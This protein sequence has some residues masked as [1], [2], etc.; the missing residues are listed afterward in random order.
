MG[1]LVKIDEI[2][3]G[4]VLEKDVTNPQGAVLLKKG[5]TIS[6]RHISI[7]KTWAVRSIYIVEEGGAEQELNGRAPEEVAQ[8]R[9]AEAQKTL[10]EK[11]ADVISSE[12]MQMIKDLTLK[13]RSE[14]IKR[15][16]NV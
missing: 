5:V 16:F 8:E 13:Q 1:K 3:A 7:F 2:Q 11:Y 6:E 9:I 4:M 14:Q 12:T 15:K 10:D